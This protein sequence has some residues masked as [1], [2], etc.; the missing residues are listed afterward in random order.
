MD[1][2]NKAIEEVEGLKPH[3]VSKH[4]WS[5]TIEETDGGKALDLFI[6]LKSRRHPEGAFLLRLRYQSDW[7]TAGRRE[8]FV[9]PEQPK[10]T[11][12]QHWPTETRGVLATQNPPAICLRGTYGFHS[13]LHADRPMGETSLLDLLLELQ[14]V[15]DET[16]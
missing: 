8:T 14:R 16:R 3:W 13:V 5:P 4:G 12:P 10:I 2:R 1:W 7:E 15:M 6:R 9:D 11:G